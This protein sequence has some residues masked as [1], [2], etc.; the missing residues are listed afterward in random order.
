MSYR[1]DS[2]FESRAIQLPGPVLQRDKLKEKFDTLLSYV[3]WATL[4]AGIIYVLTHIPPE[5]VG[6]WR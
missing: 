2:S 6:A 5:P 1:P 4:A 3:G